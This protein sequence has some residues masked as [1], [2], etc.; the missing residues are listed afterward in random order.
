LQAQFA[1]DLGS[2]QAGDVGGGRDLETG[3]QLFG[4]ASAAHEI[5]ALKDKHPSARTSKIGGGDQAVV[6][7]PDDD[8]IIADGHDRFLPPLVPSAAQPYP[9]I[10]RHGPTERARIRRRVTDHGYRESHR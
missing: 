3:P 4:H 1:N 10:E 9:T 2:Q 8:G 5:A 7:S 6:A